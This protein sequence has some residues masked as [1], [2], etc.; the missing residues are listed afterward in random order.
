MGYFFK[1][2]RDV[3]AKR[4]N[5]RYVGTRDVNRGHAKTKETE[6]IRGFGEP[7]DKTGGND[8]VGCVGEVICIYPYVL[9]KTVPSCVPL[10]RSSGTQTNIS[11]IKSDPV[12]NISSLASVHIHCDRN[13]EVPPRSGADNDLGPNDL[14]SPVPGL[15]EE[16]VEQTWSLIRSKCFHLLWVLQ[17][18]AKRSLVLSAV[19]VVFFS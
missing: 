9:L 13:D 8:G 11:I 18:A 5:A 6:C 1:G 12:P 7:D 17:K 16:H 10:R 4:N 15:P 3:G 2:D 14:S 19:G